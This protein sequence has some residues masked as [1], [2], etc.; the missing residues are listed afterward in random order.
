VNVLQ[1]WGTE[2]SPRSSQDS[3][4]IFN[5]VLTQV[6]RAILSFATYF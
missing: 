6:G 1:P 2:N 3:N 4:E 5:F